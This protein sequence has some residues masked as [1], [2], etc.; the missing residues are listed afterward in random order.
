[1][2]RIDPSE[3]EIQQ[4][5]IEYMKLINRPDVICAHVPN[6]GCFPVQYRVKLKK[7]GLFTGFPDIIIL[8][9]N[10]FGFL[11]F[12]S[13]TGRLTVDQKLFQEHCIKHEIP[14][15]IPRS[16]EDAIATIKEWGIL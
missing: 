1:M 6:E 15:S 3:D 8:W 5:F 2:M 13:K 9:G 7:M 10:R 12:K 16:L 14:H 4:S 11:E